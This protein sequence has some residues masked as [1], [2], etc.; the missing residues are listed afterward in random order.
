MKRKGTILLLVFGVC[1]ACSPKVNSSLATD[2]KNAEVSTEMRSL[3][4]QDSLINYGMNYL[5]TPYRFGGTNANGFD[6]SGFTSFVYRKFGYHL[7]H[8]S[9]GQAKQFPAISKKDLKIGDL[10][11]FEGR[12]HSGRIGHVG[13]VTELK[14]NNEFR[15]IHSTTGNG[16]IVSSSTEPYYASRYVNAGRVALDRLNLTNFN[17]NFVPSKTIENPSGTINQED[18]EEN[19]DNPIYHTVVK[20]ENLSKIAKR[21]D[22]PVSTIQALNH[23]K[24]KKIKAG[25]KL[26]ISEG[27]EEDNTAAKPTSVSENNSNIQVS[28]QLPKATPN[29]SIKENAIPES[30]H[31]NAA[32][33][34]NSVNTAILPSNQSQTQTQT[35]S[36]NKTLE[37]EKVPT[38]NSTNFSS[39]ETKH[40]VAAGETLYMIA[41]KYGLNVDELKAWNGITDN[42][43]KTGQILLVRKVENQPAPTVPIHKAQPAK[44]NH[45]IHIVKKGESLYSIARKYDC[46]VND[47]RKWNPSLSD[48]IHAGDK[49]KIEHKK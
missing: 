17:L 10:V 12:R 21:Y 3:A 37:A 44:S 16:V 28:M 46:K 9:S 24:S 2:R 30:T 48:N 31:E 1:I 29:S 36:Q 33:T 13:I 22:V 45:Q 4:F 26:L 47:L 38:A 14:D 40:K 6:C 7:D 41:K 18:D 39:N 34:T 8:S 20:G 27:E 15:F 19:G 35:T 32:N 5:N 49:I 25:Q 42:T 43:I 23:L 11:F